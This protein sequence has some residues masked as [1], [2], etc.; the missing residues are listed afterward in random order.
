[1]IVMESREKRRVEKPKLPRTAKK[2]NTKK[3]A[4]EM[5]ELGVEVDDGEE[6]HLGRA[7]S[8]S[9]SRKALKRKREQSMEVDTARSR[10]RSRTVPR[11]QSGVRDAVMA[12]KVKK[13]ANKAQKA[14]NHDA[15]KGEGDRVILDM[16]PKHLFSGKRKMG[17]TQRR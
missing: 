12:K 15:R 8:R 10:S 14:R 3:M 5:E 1:L 6:T 7:R 13:M 4:S 9:V 16:K 11:D 17:K 2:L